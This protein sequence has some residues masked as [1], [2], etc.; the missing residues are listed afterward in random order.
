MNASIIQTIQEKYK[1]F[2][3]FLNER[4]KCIGGV[5]ETKNNSEVY[6]Y[7]VLY[8]LAMGFLVKH[9]YVSFRRKIPKKERILTILAVISMKKKIYFQEIL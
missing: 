8:E 7:T 2:S 6:L 9:F 4:G 5:A 3:P 1:V